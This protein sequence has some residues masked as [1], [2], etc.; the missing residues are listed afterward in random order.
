MW[1]T[2]NFDS[3]LLLGVF[4][5][6]N[7]I[8]CMKMLSYTVACQTFNLEGTSFPLSLPFPLSLLFHPPIHPLLS[9]FPYHQFPLYLYKSS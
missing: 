6:L 4:L 5:I 2:G 3:C 9:L 1:I 8:F 7:C